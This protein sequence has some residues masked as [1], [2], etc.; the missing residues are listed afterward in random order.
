M[1]G[2]TSNER[3]S[4]DVS[5]ISPQIR[6][7]PHAPAKVTSITSSLLTQRSIFLYSRNMLRA[8][9]RVKINEKWE[10][11]WPMNMLRPLVL[12]DLISYLLFIKKLEEMQLT[13]GKTAE[14]IRNA[15]T[16]EKEKNELSWSTFKELDPQS[17]HKFFTT[18]RGLPDLLQNY[19]H[20]YRQYVPFVKEPL[21]I[22]PTA[23]LLSNMVDI[24]KI[25]EAEDGHTRMV[26]F[27]YLLNKAE[28]TGQ[29]GQVHAPEYI[30]K[31]IVALMKPTP[32]DLIWDPSAG[33]GSLL[34][35]S[36]MYI[37]NKNSGANQN[38]KKEQVTEIYTGIEA[39]LIQL[40]ICAMNMILHGIDDP[41]LEGFNVF[42]IS[43]LSLR[44]QP[45]LI[46]SNLFFESTED[47]MA[48]KTIA[49]QTE[50]RRKEI[51]FL[52]LILKNLKRGGRAAV[53]VREIILYDNLTEIKTIR[54]Q[55]I[56][57]HKLEA[58]IS[59]PGKVGSL[60]SGASLLVFT[61]P[62][63]SATDKVWFYK[64]ESAKEEKNKTDADPIH[65]GK[66]DVYASIEE[67]DSAQ[68]ILNRWKNEEDESSNRTDKSF[69]VSV[70][71]I[72]KN[73]YNFS[74]NEYRRT[75]KEPDL[76]N[77]NEAPVAVKENMHVHL[78]QEQQL[79]IDVKIKPV[80]ID[81]KVK[82][83]VPGRRV[84]R[85]LSTIFLSLL[86]IYLIVQ[87]FYFM[88]SNN[89][90]GHTNLITSKPVSNGKMKPGQ[91][92]AKQPGGMI[93]A[94]QMKAILKDSTG[95]IQFQ[96]HSDDLRASKTN[97]GK[98][99]TKNEKVDPLTTKNS[100]I[101]PEP[102]TPGNALA[103]QYMVVDTA[104]FHNQPNP[105]TS[106]KSYLDPLNKNV[107]TP[108]QDRNGFIYI[109]YT[110]HFGRTSKGWINKKNLRP[111]R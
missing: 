67:Y 109:V 43:N 38:F 33:N 28:I 60:F 37:A 14:T 99:S 12:L 45:T 105:R 41:K 23:K 35:N 47:K 77:R 17:M 75:V 32:A 83:A 42:S 66:D 16:A 25:M 110:N 2:K 19:G 50:T 72:K 61:K 85:K 21:L 57:D 79:P 13:A 52:N 100:A 62:E 111:I 76:V 22:T 97:P 86:V 54:Q 91:T 68:D 70:D 108:M 59:L 55:I 104:F 53:I 24:I 101:I 58:I 39:D 80:P 11:C 18:E 103:V 64:M 7:H 73:N 90:N 94:E 102:R 82:S 88:Y 44:E 40:R 27:E 9:L 6:N 51:R 78:K 89:K 63:S 36:A 26:I 30:V 3:V 65:P 31:L 20:I 46:L 84:M 4:E 87:A 92:S 69:Y 1:T 10:A 106:R 96:K 15:S 98:V 56:N 8:E 48:A 95:I 107:L 49:L 34:V 81:V 71:E 74:F 5:T 29:N 93:S